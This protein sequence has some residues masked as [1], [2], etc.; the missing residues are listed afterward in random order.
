V[1]FVLD[2]DVDARVA[3]TL[4]AQGHDAWTVSGAGL[5]RAVDDALTV[6]ACNHGAVLLTHDVEFSTRR[7]KNVVGW[8][9]FLRCN[10]WDGVVVVKQHLDT[11]QPVLERNL[12]LWV[13]LSLGTEPEYSYLWK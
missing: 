10:E 1:R 2:Q 8:H 13:K 12:D 11:I 9:V 6:Y 7:R 4:R 5:A 3:A